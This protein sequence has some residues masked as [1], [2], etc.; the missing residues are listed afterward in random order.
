MIPAPSAT[1]LNRL[2]YSHSGG[3]SATLQLFDVNNGYTT[4]GVPFPVSGG[5]L[6]LE[7]D[8]DVFRRCD[9][10]IAKP[11]VR[12][13]ERDTI[14]QLNVQGAEFTLFIEMYAEKGF[15]FSVQAGVFGIEDIQETDDEATLQV[16]GFDRGAKIRDFPLVTPYQPKDLNDN[17]LTYVEAIKDLITVSF[18]TA[19]PPEIVVDSALDTQAYPRPSLTL[20]G[21]RWDAIRELAEPLGAE[22]VIDNMGRFIVRQADTQAEP[23]W[24]IGPGEGGVL[25]SREV[26]RSRSEQYNAVALTVEPPDSNAQDNSNK[27]FVYLVDNDP[28]SP[29]YYD[30]PFGKKPV[31][32]RNDTP[33]TE[34]QAIN[35]AALELGKVSG[36]ARE[37]SFESLYNPL[38]EPGDRIEL[39]GRDGKSEIHIIDSLEFELADATMSGATRLSRGVGHYSDL[40][41]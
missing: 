32:K 38:L 15:T 31:S 7:T 12:T 17:R 18:S 6:S 16:I 1:Y 30:G 36:A 28:G 40:A 29:T 34:Q 8:S 3:V 9:L 20:E 27:F 14:Q 25:V 23:V 4:F 41:T 19:A 37:I 21:D 26:T 10:E 35:A 33:T 11:P 2:A 39:I 5:S 24:T 22:V 13:P